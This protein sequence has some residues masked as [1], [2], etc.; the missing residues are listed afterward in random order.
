MSVPDVVI[1]Y[2]AVLL[3]AFAAMIIGSLWYSPML[4][5]GIWMKLSGIKMK[6][7]RKAKKKGMGKAYFLA[8]IG[9]LIMACVL[10]HFLKYVGATGIGDALQLASWI[11]LGFI[12]PIQ[13]GIVLW[14]GKPVKLY[15]INTLYYLVVF[16]VMS[17]V[18]VLWQ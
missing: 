15:L 6:N 10:A 3:S 7:A 11:W 5:G 8:F 4:F 16:I 2:W 14:E 17:I 9:A 18:L 12:A 13:L 1:N